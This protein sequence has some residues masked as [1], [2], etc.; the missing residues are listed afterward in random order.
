MPKWQREKLLRERESGGRTSFSGG[1]KL[2]VRGSQ[3]I[4]M[5]PEKEGYLT[6]PTI[7]TGV[8]RRSSAASLSSMGRDARSQSASPVKPFSRK[9]S[10]ST[11]EQEIAILRAQTEMAQ[12]TRMQISD[13]YKREAADWIS[14][15][16]QLDITEDNLFE[17]L[18]DGV[19]LCKLAAKVTHGEV[20]WR[21]MRHESEIE[22]GETPFP[23]APSALNPRGHKAIARDNCHRFL[24]WCKAVGLP[25]EVLFE[26]EDLV[27]FATRK[28]AEDKVLTCLLDVAR[29]SHNVM[30]PT[31]VEKERQYLADASKLLDAEIEAELAR[32]A[33]EAARLEEEARLAAERAIEE[34]RLAAERAAEEARLA[35]ERAAEEAQLAAEE[36]EARQAAERAAEAARQLA[37]AARIKAEEE[38]RLAA[39][40]AARVARAEAAAA[41]AKAAAD[42][43]AAA[44]A[45]AA[46][47]AAAAARAAEIKA[48][49]AQAAAE[50]AAAEKAAA[51]KL[52]AEELAA[53]EEAARLV[54][55]EAA[56]KAAEDAARIKAE[57]VARVAAAA[58]AVRLAA[59]EERRHALEE[60]A[61]RAAEEETLRLQAEGAR[62]QAERL[63]LEDEVRLER[64]RLEKLRQDR[65][66]AER[67]RREAEARRAEAEA[68]RD[69]ERHAADAAA[70]RAREEEERRAA[71]EK[72]ERLAREATLAAERAAAEAA[73]RQRAE[74]EAQ[75]LAQLELERMEREEAELNRR[76]AAEAEAERIKA[77]EAAELAALEAELAKVQLEEQAAL[78]ELASDKA[79]AAALLDAR[80]SAVAATQEAAAARAKA[81]RA[82]L[83]LL[84]EQ[85]V[86][87]AAALTASIAALH[88]KSDADA[89]ERARIEQAEAENQSE[90]FS[91]K[92]ERLASVLRVQSNH[93]KLLREQQEKLAVEQELAMK[94]SEDERQAALAAAQLAQEEATRMAEKRRKEEDRLMNAKYNKDALDV[95]VRKMMHQMT[96]TV[97]L[98]RLRS[99]TY[100][101]K[102]TT[103]KI[104][105][106]ILNTMIMVRVGG[107]WEKLE[108]WLARHKPQLS[109]GSKS[110]AKKRLESR[111]KSPIQGAETATYTVG[112]GDSVGTRTTLAR[113]TKRESTEGEVLVLGQ[114]AKAA[115]AGI[116]D[117]AELAQGKQTQANAEYDKQEAVVAEMVAQEK[118]LLESAAAIMDQSMLK[119]SDEMSRFADATRAVLEE[120]QKRTEEEIKRRQ[121]EVAELELEL[122]SAQE[123][124]QAEV[125]LLA[126]KIV[127][128]QEEEAALQEQ[129][130]A[131]SADTDTFHA[132]ADAEVAAAEATALAAAD[133]AH[134]A[135]TDEKAS[136]E[137]GHVDKVATKRSLFGKLRTKIEERRTEIRAAYKARVVGSGVDAPHD[138]FR[139]P[140]PPPT[141]SQVGG[142][143]PVVV[144][145]SSSTA[146]P[147]RPAPTPASD[148][149]T[150]VASDSPTH[151]AAHAATKPAVTKVVL[152]E[153]LEIG[154]RVAT[155]LGEGTLMWLGDADF[156][157]KGVVQQWCGIGMDSTNEAFHDGTFDGVRYFD[158]PPGRGMFCK[159]T[160]VTVL[161]QVM[162]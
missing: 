37:E 8:V 115:D 90:G 34:A 116:F 95:E 22:E 56:R 53:A 83:T 103:K 93:A 45:A 15:L 25:E 44:E 85:T 122:A 13:L 137:I 66:E 88:S 72:R 11:P 17:H 32:E 119:D 113:S 127:L 135:I 89:A 77:A 97:Q 54:A 121:D 79:E 151:V 4:S 30:V 27:G 99:G 33:A 98:I 140:S 133:A 92:R 106:R 104:F 16:F 50:N 14:Q 146:A 19:L 100:L 118:T 61:R 160:K 48:A 84:K 26:S 155:V 46:E 2:V 108:N 63:R 91:K 152:Q 36:E 20:E 10:R 142:T 144:V 125:D 129:H 7:N 62:I 87:K 1:S 86:T 148:S 136:V 70:K 147:T 67:L 120:T 150:T 68:R 42:A 31:V 123:R 159:P 75:R 12:E 29:R 74:D 102:G 51:E 117:E 55:I 162:L 82:R 76:R 52:A 28:T 154:D 109:E 143:N 6:S 105:V 161:R 110:D 101:I 107:G 38:V 145:A 132:T 43:K 5:S 49:Q 78:A 41:A 80:S 81:D 47:A 112:A 94:Q 65:L 149:P 111:M 131:M 59:E 39:E 71:E 69:A 24:Q 124:S 3:R 134:Q 157:R 126:A 9:I 18:M 40:E 58:E 73:A 64:Q 23:T 158:C 60:A 139:A 156:S 57:E 138:R 130:T 141:A 114:D 21:G 128:A 35:A 96:T 153:L